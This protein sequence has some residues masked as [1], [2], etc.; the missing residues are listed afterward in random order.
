MSWKQQM[1]ALSG[2]HAIEKQACGNLVLRY[3]APACNARC[4]RKGNILP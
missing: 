3:A 4:Q 2:L 1:I